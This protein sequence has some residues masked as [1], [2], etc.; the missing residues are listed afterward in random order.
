MKT[1]PV[2]IIGGGLAGCE[3]A[4]Q[5]LRRGHAVHLY[6]M[7]PQKFSP[8]HKM[9]HLA[10]LVCSNS[11]KSNSLDNAPGLL[12]EEMR[13]LNSIII[14]AAD[15]TAVAAG[16]ALA[17]DRIQFASEVEAQLQMQKNFIRSRVEVTKIPQ[18]SPT[19]I[20]TGPLTSD[21]LAQEISKTLDSSYLYFYDAI[22]PIVEADSID[23][24]KVFWASRYDKGTPDYLNCPLSKEEYELFRQELL[25]GEKVAI[26]PF[27]EVRHFESCLPI[28][29]L[30]SR[31]EK[32]LAFGP[33]KP[34]GLIHPKTGSISYA[35][36]QL[37]REN[38]AGTL[39]NM[40]GFQTKLTWPEQ[41]RI[42]RL[43]PGLENAQFARYGSIHRNT[44]IHSPS[45]LL[46]SLQLKNNEN[47]FFAGQITGVEG[48]TESAAMGLLAGLNAA[49]IIEGK[50]LQPPPIKTAI[51]AL[52]HYIVSAESA[53]RFQ[54]MNINFG[55][56]DTL[57]GK[58]LKKKEKNIL[59]VNQA[60]QSLND[61]ITNQNMN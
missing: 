61:W 51:G 60:L 24:D 52:L 53:D 38:M 2:I 56:L 16:S 10:E 5:L 25:A 6:E 17:V 8:A 1:S 39:F 40:V 34:V 30:A 31:G 43:I 7:K 22:A 55:L 41:R 4:W 3:A 21:A 15:R 20:A 49:F 42:F 11:L 37:R 46:P 12:K 18:D 14:A 19:I 57:P 23:M 28:E 47:I 33:M 26:K 48:Y 35:V 13:R 36:V 27:E 9:E 44:F 50:P 32:S 59:H 54:P 45:L 29:V 58:K